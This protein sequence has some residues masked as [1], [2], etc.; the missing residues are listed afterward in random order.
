MILSLS[1]HILI[2][3]CAS[4][5]RRRQNLAIVDRNAGGRCPV[6]WPALER[7]FPGASIDYEI[8]SDEANEKPRERRVRSTMR[9]GGSLTPSGARAR[10]SI[11]LLVVFPIISADA[12]SLWLHTSENAIHTSLAIFNGNAPCTFARYQIRRRVVLHASVALI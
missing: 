10:V 1:I 6:D 2:L 9:C 4:Q 5:S 3:F 8:T 12:R 7:P 11:P